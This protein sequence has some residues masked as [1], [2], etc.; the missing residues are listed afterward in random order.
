MSPAQTVFAAATVK[1]RASRFGAMGRAWLLSVV[2]MQKRR[3]PRPSRPFYRI[4]RWTRRLPMRTRPPSAAARRDAIH[5]FHALRCRL[6][7]PST[8]KSGLASGGGAGRSS[9]AGHGADDRPTALTPGTRNCTHTG[10]RSLFCS[11]QAHFIAAPSR[12]TP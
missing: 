3:L 4:V 7:G 2:P 6:P 9:S 10:Q 8:S 1:L 5:T 11:I 12:W